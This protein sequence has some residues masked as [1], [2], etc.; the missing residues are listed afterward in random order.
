MT[1]GNLDTAVPPVSISPAESGGRFE[2]FKRFATQLVRHPETGRRDNE[3]PE[4]IEVVIPKTM[5]FRDVDAAMEYDMECNRKLRVALELKTLACS[6]LGLAA[7]CG[8]SV[9]VIIGLLWIL[10]Y[11]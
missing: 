9:A 3:V 10:R 2:A 1:R 5:I 11:A 7:A 8:W 6:R 4:P